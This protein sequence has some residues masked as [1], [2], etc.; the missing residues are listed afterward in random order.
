MPRLYAVD[1]S[2]GEDGARYDTL[3]FPQ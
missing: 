1:G 3:A 2:D